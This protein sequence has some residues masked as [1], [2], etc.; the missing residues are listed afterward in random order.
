MGVSCEVIGYK[1]MSG[2][3]L[4]DDSSK[5]IANE[6]T[7]RGQTRQE[8]RDTIIGFTEIVVPT[9]FMANWRRPSGYSLITKITDAITKGSVMS[10]PMMFT[11]V[12]I[13]K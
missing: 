3:K 5:R 4:V 2:E 13:S 9:R 7:N 10:L 1:P 11:Q 12:D 8:V 6:Q